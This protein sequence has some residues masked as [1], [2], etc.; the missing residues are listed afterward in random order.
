[1]PLRTLFQSQGRNRKITSNG[2]E[3]KSMFFRNLSLLLNNFQ[4]RYCIE[5]KTFSNTFETYSFKF[6]DVDYIIQISFIRTS[7]LYLYMKYLLLFQI[8]FRNK[9]H[10]QRFI[11]FPLLVK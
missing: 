6:I 2:T 5:K 8:Y 10:T 9:A 11:K 1:M 7:L 3:V 4:P